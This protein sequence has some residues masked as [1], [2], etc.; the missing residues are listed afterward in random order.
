MEIEKQFMRVPDKSPACGPNCASSLRS[1]CARESDN[2]TLNPDEISIRHPDA[3]PGRDQ[4][5]DRS[6]AASLRTPQP[7]FEPT[8][9]P[10]EGTKSMKVSPCLFKF[11]WKLSNSATLLLALTFLIIGTAVT[12][13]SFFLCTDQ[14]TVQARLLYLTGAKARNETAKE[15]I[16]SRLLRAP[17]IV[18]AMEKD[19]FSTA[20]GFRD[21]TSIEQ[22][23][24]TSS[25][26]AGDIG[27]PQQK[28]APDSAVV[29]RRWFSGHLSVESEP[30]GRE[31]GLTVSLTGSNPKLMK[32]L[33]AAYLVHYA[34]WRRTVTGPIQH[35]PETHE[36]AL[37]SSK[38]ETIAKELEKI[39]GYE[40]NCLLALDLLKG[41]RSSVFSG[42]A[43]DSGGMGI[44]ILAAF[45]ARIIKLNL[46]K[47]ELLSEFTPQSREVRALDSQIQRVRSSMRECL[48]EHLKFVQKDKQRLLAYKAEL[49]QKKCLS[50]STGGVPGKPCKA[51]QFGKGGLLTFRNGVQVF[52]D[53]SFAVKKHLLL[54]LGEANKALDDC[55]GSWI[56]NSKKERPKHE[57]D[58]G[59]VAAA[60]GPRT[61]AGD[62]AAAKSKSLIVPNSSRP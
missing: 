2:N 10:A 45:E 39:D 11:V 19:L 17:E 29:F 8:E 28:W 16:E 32:K 41:A 4:T 46:K 44:P 52:W 42:F 22:V 18:T 60:C 35:T 37:S 21:G 25:K 62:L 7:E 6:L 56:F 23:R 34:D 48:R 20:A 57:P 55:V 31:L 54:S 43:P 36:P 12:V 13:L 1:G 51:V 14:Y 61:S 33:L 30:H 49:E 50:K 24:L 27:S 15:E 3:V 59:Q 40:R 58:W 53:G 5:G 26:S 9:Q 38:V 47:A